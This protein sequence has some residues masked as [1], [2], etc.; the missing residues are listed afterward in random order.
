MA[1]IQMSNQEVSFNIF[2]EECEHFCNRDCVQLLYV[3]S[4]TVM[5]K[6]GKKHKSFTPCALLVIN[7]LE[8]YFCDAQTGTFITLT[9]PLSCLRYAGIEQ[10]GRISCCVQDDFPG[11]NSEFQKIRTA[12]AN[13]WQNCFDGSSRGSSVL[14]Q[15]VLKLF[16]LL[17]EHFSNSIGY[18]I[19]QP[20]A[21][22]IDYRLN[23][24][25]DYIHRHWQDSLCVADISS[26]IYISP[27]YLS[28][29]WRKYMDCTL[30]EYIYDVRLDYV[31]KQLHGTKNIT[32][33]ASF[34]GFQN[35]GSMNKK[36]FQQFGVT[37]KQYR[38]RLK[39]HSERIPLSLQGDSPD[40]TALL[41]YA[42]AP[43]DSAKH[44]VE[45]RELVID[46]DTPGIPLRHTWR[47]LVNIGYAREG[48]VELVQE[49]LIRAQRE[50][51]F[52]YV[53]FHGIFDDD[54]HVFFENGNGELQPNYIFTDLLLDF[55]L[56]IDLKPFIEFGYVPKSLTSHPVR[57]LER[58]TY[59]S[60]INDQDKWC[61]LLSLFLY[62]VIARYGKETVLKWRFTV[63][64]SEL[65]LQGYLTTEDYMVHYVSSFRAV[66]SVCPSLQ[67][68]G[69][70]GH[71]SLIQETEEFKEFV[72]YCIHE[73][74]VPDFFCIQNFPVSYIKKGDA[75][76]PVLLQKLSP[77][78]ISSDIHYSTHLLKKAQKILDHHHLEERE[79]WFEE[80]N[81]SIWQRD[82]AHDTCYKAAWLVK[83]ICENYDKAEAF[84]YWL[85]TDFIEERL[86]HD[87]LTYFGGNSLITYNGIPKA[88]WNAMC[89]LR[90]LG[91]FCIAS[92]DG[93]YVTRRGSV[94]Q[95][96]LYQ[97]V[98]YGDMY[99]FCNQ[100]PINIDR[101]YDIF[102]SRA[103][104]QYHIVIH[105]KQD[106]VCRIKKYTVNRSNGSSFDSWVAMGKP[107][108]MEPE[109]IE[110][111]KSISAYALEVQELHL[112][113]SICLD[114]LL[115]T[116]NVVLYELTFSQ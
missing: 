10:C 38:K 46:G 98:H 99:R 44:T 33:I 30:F 11:I 76:N 67:F 74:C 80:W 43:D 105:R 27:N 61:K 17:R 48:L 75:A 102:L 20:D 60:K 106:A 63:G 110:Y 77:V 4:G 8:W 9:I 108:Y 23:C 56:S 86:P 79:I 111:L 69:F 112:Q 93:Y 47:K 57:V 53:R 15:N 89:L 66:K 37:P 91:D 90:K 73:N 62:H 55:L 26:Y 96:L 41:L 59:F 42:D 115:S 21:G 14:L 68:G 5:I 36:F 58:E 95:I 29:L 3:L 39:I 25:I 13:L 6:Y 32:E 16:T 114:V 18:N 78:T 116:H 97:Y 51:G 7:P 24:A 50:I 35:T 113:E 71:S 22:S 85:L 104:R 84:G 34:C 100:A 109:E 2:R 28:R 87:G 19:F 103:D 54:M 107:K 92:G 12:L 81:A 88:G 65:K 83:D 72:E 64:G 49:Q 70:G 45:Q 31:E 1:G 94:I 101:T 52:E 40:L 82:M